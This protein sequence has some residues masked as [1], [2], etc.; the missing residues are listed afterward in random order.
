MDSLIIKSSILTTT[1]CIIRGN[2]TSKL[3]KYLM[4]YIGLVVFLTIQFIERKSNKKNRLDIFSALIFYICFQVNG[5]FGPTPI[6]T[7]LVLTCLV[8]LLFL[9]LLRL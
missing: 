7:I 6:Y 5:M 9:K 4:L 1:L 8:T 2:E 3:W